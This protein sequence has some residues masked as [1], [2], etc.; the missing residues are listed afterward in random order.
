MVFRFRIHAGLA[1]L[2]VFVAMGTLVACGDRGDGLNNVLGGAGESCTKT[3]DCESGLKCVNLVCQQA[4]AECPG[5]QDCSGLECGPD[6]V[7]SESCG[8]CGGGE[9]CQ[10]GQCVEGPC[11]P[12]CSGLEC[13]N[14]GCPDQPDACGTCSDG[15]TCDA[16]ECSAVGPDCPVDKDCTGLESGPDLVCGESCGTCF[17][18]DECVD[19]QCECQPDCVGKECGNDGCGGSCGSCNAGW[20]CD[21]GKCIDICT[22]TCASKGWE[23]D[24]VCEESCG[25]CWGQDECV[26]GQCVCQPNCAGQEC[27]D[28]G[29][30]GSCGNCGQDE[31]CDAQGQ[32]VPST[33][34]VWKPIPGGT[35]TMG[36]S[37]NDGKCGNNEKPA[38]SVTLSAFEIL[39]TEVTEAQYEAVTGEDPSCDYSGGGG[40]DSPVECIDW[41][42]AKA[43]CEAVGG[44]LCTEA[45]WEYAARGGTT[46]PY[47]CGDSSSCLD[48][49][50]WYNSNSW[51][52][53]HDVKGKAPNPYGLYDML[54]NVWEWTADWYDDDYY[55]VSPA[56]NPNGPNSGSFRVV[57]GGF[58]GFAGGGLRVSRRVYYG[59]S[60][61]AATLGGRCCKS[62][63][64]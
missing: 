24:E 43:F 54:G 5:N 30:G 55:D 11:E 12:D 23:C 60:V 9:S 38:H 14:G 51:G 28:D 20:V 16:G 7:C 3:A 45:E 39:E 50:A 44:R 2:L 40:A 46:T 42:D 35:F 25:T 64:E 59:P 4:G 56:N 48:G 33:G 36:C 34:L 18:Q 19:G 27:G 63:D 26:N 31:E 53:K 29:C 49:I 1:S 17:G 62:I 13:G 6:P 41:Y 32:C 52:H 8:T 47:Y 58:F 61:D 21:S 15:F 22:D 37:P 10:A 57:R